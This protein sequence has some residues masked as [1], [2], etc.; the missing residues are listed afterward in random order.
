MKNQFVYFPKKSAHGYYDKALNRHFSS[1]TEK[2]DYMNTHGL[3]EMPSSESKKHLIN[4]R[5]D[6]INYQREKQGL[7]PKT[8]AEL[9]GVA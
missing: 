1:K 6:Y 5:V 2:R 4:D 9:V 3:V 8:K 7:R